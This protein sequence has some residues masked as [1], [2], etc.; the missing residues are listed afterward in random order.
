ML[1]AQL[2]G[3]KSARVHSGQLMRNVH[4]GCTFV[5][6][7]INTRSRCFGLGVTSLLCCGW[8]SLFIRWTP[9][10]HMYFFQIK[11]SSNVN[12]L[13]Q[14]QPAITLETFAVKLKIRSSWSLS[15]A[16]WAGWF[17]FDWLS[18]QKKNTNWDL[19][20]CQTKRA[21]P[22]KVCIMATISQQLQ[23]WLLVA[24]DTL[25]LLAQVQLPFL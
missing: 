2:S 16:K 17:L 19:I 24:L 15:A 7:Q 6:S 11:S 25:L 3:E 18:N 23:S 5:Q 10:P 20:G 8:L 9:V 13:K 4:T 22:T 12:E 1:G 21:T 14:R